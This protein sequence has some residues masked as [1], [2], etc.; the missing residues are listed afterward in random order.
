VAITSRH[1]ASGNTY[2]NMQYAW[3]VSYNTIS[4]VVREAMEAI[5]EEY[6]DIILFC[7]TPEQGWRDLADQWYQRWNFPHTVGAIDDNHVACKAPLT[8][9]ENFTT[10]RAFTA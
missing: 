2:R 5:N 1:L 4:V 7:P 6:T 8:L 3:R 9:A 10:I